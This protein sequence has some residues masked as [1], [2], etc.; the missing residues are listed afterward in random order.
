MTATGKETKVGT[1]IYLFFTVAAVWISFIPVQTIPMNYILIYCFK[2]YWFLQ[3]VLLL[4]FNWLRQ[5]RLLNL[6]ILC[7]QV[8]TVRCIPPGE[9]MP[10]S[11]W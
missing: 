7:L 10:T 8:Y 3:Y 1:F 2:I 6:L 9:T 5:G 4:V 11:S